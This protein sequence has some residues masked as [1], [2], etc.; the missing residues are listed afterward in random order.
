MLKTE[1]RYST[2]ALEDRALFLIVGY[3]E[4]HTIS[5]RRSSEI[6][7]VGIRRKKKGGKGRKIIFKS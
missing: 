7:K 6:D 2:G 5:P 1:D 3:S 4:Q